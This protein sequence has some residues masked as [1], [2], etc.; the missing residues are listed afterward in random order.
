MKNL[1]DHTKCEKPA[2][3]VKYD[4][5]YFLEPARKSCFAGRFG[6]IIQKETYNRE[7]Y[8]ENYWRLTFKARRFG[9]ILW[10]ENSKSKELSAQYFSTGY[11]NLVELTYLNEYFALLLKN[12]KKKKFRISGNYSLVP[13]IMKSLRLS[14][15]LERDLEGLIFEGESVDDF[16]R[17]VLL[18][19]RV[20][21]FVN[22]LK[23]ILKNFEIN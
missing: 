21:K 23:H 8:K 3:F 1:S 14:I 19:N 10:D 2:A 7:K 18:V 13:N 6:A 12:S 5:L 9:R 11:S 4:R 16:K 15:Q 17:L 20:K 22:N